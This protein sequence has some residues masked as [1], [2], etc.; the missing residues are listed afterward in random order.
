MTKAATSGFFVASI[1]AVAGLPH[2]KGH[3]FWAAVLTNRYL[4]LMVD[5]QQL[6]YGFRIYRT[7]IIC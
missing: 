3:P 6:I 7:T 5:L 1:F 2:K 4:F